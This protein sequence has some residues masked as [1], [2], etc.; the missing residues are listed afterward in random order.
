MPRRH[1]L[2]ALL[3][4]VAALAL[5]ALAATTSA[6]SASSRTVAPPPQPVAATNDP[7]RASA[8]TPRRLLVP[9]LRGQPYVFAKGILDDAGFSWRVAGAVRGYP[10]NVV[11]TQSPPPGTRVVDTGSPPVVL[12]LRR[13]SDYRQRGIP[14][15]ASPRRPTRLVLADER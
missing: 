15:D 3:L 5:V 10:G 8:R 12:R 9:D 14:V 2:V 11:E 13:A 4:R 1:S 6:T 7:E